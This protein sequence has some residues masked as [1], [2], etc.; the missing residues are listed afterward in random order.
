MYT[1]QDIKIHKSRFSQL[2]SYLGRECEIDKDIVEEIST[3]RRW[4]RMEVARPAA[5]EKGGMSR[6]RNCCPFTL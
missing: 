1:K 4:G 6:V 2:E 3:C 5:G